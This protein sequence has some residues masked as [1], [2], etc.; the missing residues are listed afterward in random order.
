[1]SILMFNAMMNWNCLYGACMNNLYLFSEG[2]VNAS[3]KIIRKLQYFVTMATF[4]SDH[5]E[6]L[7]AKYIYIYIGSIKCI[8]KV[9]RISI[10]LLTTGALYRILH[11]NGDKYY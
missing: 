6:V 1:M 10:Y 11:R 9:T 4:I 5:N 8:A 7:N 2:K 3:Q